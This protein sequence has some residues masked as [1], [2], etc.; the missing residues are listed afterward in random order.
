[1][2]VLVAGV[3][4]LRLVPLY[5][6]IQTV[7]DHL[8]R[9]LREQI[10]G[11]RVVRAFARDTHERRRFG[12]ASTELYRLGL[13]ASRR[14]GTLF[15]AVVLIGNVFT[16]GVIW[17]GSHLV[18][19]GEIEVGGLSAFLG[20]LVLLLTSMVIAMYA[21][22]NVPR[23][24]VSA[25]RIQ[26]VLSTRPA[27]VP[28]TRRG[29][30]GGRLELRGVG[31]RHPGAEAPFL[32]DIELSVGQGERVAIIGGTGSGKTTLLNLVLRLADVT[33]GV[34]RVNGVDVREL[35]TATIA[36]TIGL[37]PQRPILFSG[38]V[39]TNL[40]YGAADATDA[41]LWHA[42]EV[43]QAR[44]FVEATPGGLDARISQGGTNI[45]GG[46]RQR[47]SIARTLLRGPDIY[48]LDDCFSALDQATDA[49]LRAALAAETRNAT[50]I[51]VAQRVSTIEH[52]DLIV[53]L[54]EGRIV[55]T[56]THDEL[57][58]SSTA[59]REIVNS[60]LRAEEVH[61]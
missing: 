47:L 33:S 39:A 38:T 1:V 27:M 4:I 41:E 11:V 26:E 14:R 10:T 17:V 13:K 55:G 29:H 58:A 15:P 60:Q 43:T 8:N 25:R 19:T 23:A 45:S 49:N 12:R 6:R 28:G 21:L 61:R 56:G 44:A 30:G 31:F 18:D 32:Q 5:D 42:L 2:T 46:Q 37:V 20:Y 53:V 16:V 54:H 36:G 59:Y 34:V 24:R 22:V 51:V 35:D 40:R 57:L 7:T 50:M 3:I 52:A 9:V 48:L